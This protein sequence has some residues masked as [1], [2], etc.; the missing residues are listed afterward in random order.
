MRSV[1]TVSESRHVAI[2]GID[3][4]DYDGEDGD[5]VD[6]GG[7]DRGARVV[8]EVRAGLMA[9]GDV[10]L[11]EEVRALFFVFVVVLYLSFLRF[12]PSFIFFLWVGRS[13]HTTI[14]TPPHPIPPFFFIRPAP[15]TFR[16]TNTITSRPA[17]A[18]GGKRDQIH[19]VV[20]D[21]SRR[22]YS[23]A[24]RSRRCRRCGCA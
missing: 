9:D 7:G 19:D 11:V 24:C 3:I 22:N 12:L 20:G 8:D 1:T 4:D 21:P 13:A 6:E 10:A 23:T 17:A 18:R 5:D 16:F 15:R 14:L 2:V